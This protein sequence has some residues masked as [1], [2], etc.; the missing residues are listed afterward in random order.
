[1]YTNNKN[2]VFIVDEIIE[3]NYECNSLLKHDITSPTVSVLRKDHQ[4]MALIKKLKLM[5]VT[6]NVNFK[7]DIPHCKGRRVVFH[8]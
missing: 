7:C 5:M 2:Y 8:N 3:S 1:M 4:F 6:E